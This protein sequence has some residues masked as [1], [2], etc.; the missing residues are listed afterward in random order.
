MRSKLR[1][2]DL[3][4]HRS[5][6]KI[7]NR[8]RPPRRVAS[9]YSQALDELQLARHLREKGELW[10]AF[11]V[12][13]AA[14]KAN[15]SADIAAELSSMI[16]TS[17]D[18]AEVLAAMD[19][20]FDH[21]HYL[22][23]NSDVRSATSDGRT[24]YL[25]YGWK[26]N[27]DPSAFF[28]SY[29]YSRRH[30]QL[31][32]KVFQLSHFVQN[33][34]DGGVPANAVSDRYWF[35][36]T[37][38]SFDEWQNV[39]PAK[40][41]DR[42]KAVVVIPVY[43]GFEETMR[44][45]YQALVARKE[46]EYSLLVVNDKGP[47]QELNRNLRALADKGLF[48]YHVNVVNRGFV[49]TCNYAINELTKNLDVVLLNSDAYVFPGWFGRLSAHANDSSVAT[50]TPLSNNA[51]IC[52]YP[53]SDR[54]NRLS[55]ECTPE[56]VDALA[57][58]A[59]KGAAVEAPTGVGFC[60][61]MSRK[62][63]NKIGALDADAFKVGYGEENDFCMRALNHGYK[64]L[65]AGDV[66]V[67][68]TGSVSFSAIKEENFNKGQQALTG[69]HPNYSSLV[70]SHVLADPERHLRRK[71][72]V[73]RLAAAFQG[74]TIFVSHNWTGGINTYLAQERSKLD[75]QGHPHLTICV[76]DGYKVTIDADYKIFVPNLVDIDLRSDLALIESLFIA[77]QPRNFHVNSLAG[78][79]WFWH[80]KLLELITGV[81]IPYR[82]ICHDYSPISHNYQLLRPD[83]I[84]RH[85]PNIGERREWLGMVDT[86]GGSDVCDPDER[87]ATYTKFLQSADT[88]EVPSQA[89]KRILQAEF[90]DVT[91]LVVPHSD[92]LPDVEIAQRREPDGKIRVAIIGA[93]GP[94]KGSDVVAA[95]AADAKYR[96]LELE[97]VLVGYSNNDGLLQSSGVEI[98]G[99]YHT[100]MEAMTRLAEVKP[101]IVFI[102]SIWPETFCY[103]LSMALKLKI[104]PVVFDIGA[105]NERVSALSW[106]KA[107]PIKLAYDPCHLSEVFLRLE[108]DTM[109]E[110]RNDQRHT[111]QAA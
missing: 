1:L 104:P 36:P 68:H 90:P 38:P 44:A 35:I 2:L 16:G 67:F 109:W 40:L 72:D 85:I 69:K 101:D 77:M 24:H 10:Q 82:Y 92:H 107:I 93:V 96:G 75:E 7:A 19:S 17:T 34:K 31:D 23:S 41:S 30:P 54:D 60:F 32:P 66:F 3:F 25:L 91:F 87:I 42:T 48:D 64:N 49:Q 43:K 39:T 5:P 55:L 52:S 58:V 51:T 14:Y 76:H 100:E 27:R 79:D 59:N 80:K 29:F 108:L 57:A 94:H 33:G 83:N 103:T 105:Q 98:T 65:V 86:L 4:K 46:D 73:A 81:G 50:V 70:R 78:L 18:Y 110:A 22:N 89:A 6:S 95:L 74:A 106:G 88:V 63:I 47:D 15:P 11:N 53:L 102:P 97:Y 20:E 45:I 71:L 8:N 84:Y 28:D 9:E 21:A 99:K 62:V 12:L 37:V 56:Q 13:D 111:E 26:E 61:Y